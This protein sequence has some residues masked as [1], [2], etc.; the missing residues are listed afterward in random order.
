MNAKRCPRCRR[1]FSRWFF[2][3]GKG[4]FCWPCWDGFDG[5]ASRLVIMKSKS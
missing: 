5:A 3:P 4:L 1:P 2:W